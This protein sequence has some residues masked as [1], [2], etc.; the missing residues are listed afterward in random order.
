[1]CV[2]VSLYLLHIEHAKKSFCHQSEDIVA[3]WCHFRPPDFK[4]LFEGLDLVSRLRFRI[5]RRSG[6]L[7]G[8]FRVRVGSWV[9]YCIMS[10]EVP[11]KIEVQGCVS[12]WVPTFDRSQVR[13]RFSE[14]LAVLYCF[15]VEHC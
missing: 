12:V 15:D 13:V 1:M 5:G 11:T 14:A 4:G 6:G 3:K 8:M 2:Y 7:V 10:V 9:I